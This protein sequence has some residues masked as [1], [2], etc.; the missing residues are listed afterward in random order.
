[1]SGFEKVVDCDSGEEAD[2]VR[3]FFLEVVNE[4][5]IFCSGLPDLIKFRNLQIDNRSSLFVCVTTTMKGRILI[6]FHCVSSL[7]G[8]VWTEKKTSRL[9]AA[10]FPIVPGGTPFG[11][12]EARWFDFDTPDIFLPLL[13]KGD[14]G[15]YPAFPFEWQKQAGEKRGRSVTFD[16]RTICGRAG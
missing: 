14:C 16:L 4:E 3:V 10:T 15:A 1:M 2:R 9:G 7:P 11:A 6:R 5:A 13:G 8:T 12:A